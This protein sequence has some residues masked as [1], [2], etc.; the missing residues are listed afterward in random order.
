MLCYGDSNTW[1][2]I[3]GSKRFERYSAK[4]RWPGILQQLLGDGYEVIEA[5]LNSRTTNLDDPDPENPGRNGLFLLM[6][7]LESHNRV[8]IIIFMLGTNDLKVQYN[9]QPED[10]AVGMQAL[11]DETSAYA[12]KVCNLRPTIFLISPPLVKEVGR[13]IYAGGTI[14]SEK[15][16]ALYQKLAQQNSQPNEEVYFVNAAQYV[17]PSEIDGVHLEES[18]HK[19]LAEILHTLLKARKIK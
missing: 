7:T 8:D 15:L 5:G 18:G 16:A 19:K 17:Q 6:P 1:G 3:P 14:K 11:L 4:E 10:V 9:R 13:E 2:K 12:K